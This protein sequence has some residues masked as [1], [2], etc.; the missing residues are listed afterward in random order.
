LIGKGMVERALKQRKH[1][2]IFMVDI[3]VPRDIE[4]EVADLSDVFLYTVDDLRSVI[5]DSKRQRAKAAVE[6]R[7][8][9][10]QQTASFI[11]NLNARSASDAIKLIRSNADSIRQ[12]ELDKAIRALAAGGDPS[13]VSKQLAHNITNKLMHA[14]TV[15]LR[16]AHEQ[17]DS[18]AS[19]WALRLFDIDG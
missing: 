16:S 3:A 1:K 18:A 4:S 5:E 7:L 10:D 9:I 13:V 17:G 8:I 11:T 12:R 2:P 15:A 19:D 6:A 14:P